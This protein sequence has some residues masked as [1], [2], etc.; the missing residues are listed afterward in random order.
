MN[1]LWNG[2]HPHIKF[3]CQGT[4][5]CGFVGAVDET[6][7]TINLTSRNNI[8]QHDI[9]VEKTDIEN[10]V[11]V[12]MTKEFQFADDWTS[13]D[14]DPGMVESKT[15]TTVHD[16][17]RLKTLTESQLFFEYF[18]SPALGVDLWNYHLLPGTNSGGL[19]QKQIGKISYQIWPDNGLVK[20]DL[21][22]AIRLELAS[23]LKGGPREEFFCS[24]WYGQAKAGGIAERTPF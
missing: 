5:Y 1:D 23:R 9:T 13:D 10:I 8:Q 19:L 20:E 12:P 14:G 24:K 2:F 21:M 6:N 3:E 15:D 4:R 22:E 16:S 18:S 17:E 7:I 11:Y